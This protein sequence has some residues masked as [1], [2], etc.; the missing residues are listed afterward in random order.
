MKLN[1][2]QLIRQS[3]LANIDHPR[4]RN[5]GYRVGYDGKGRICVGTG[6]ITYNATIG[7]CCM[8]IM[9]DHVEPGAS[10]KNKDTAE[11]NA[12][13]AFACIGNVAIIKSGDAKGETGFVTGKHGGV[14][15]VMIHF[16]H[17]TLLLMDG[18]EKILIQGFG[19]GLK[20]K[21]IPAI[22]VMNID[23]SLLTKIA[24]VTASLLNIAV[25]HIIPSYLMGS[26]LGSSTTMLGD[27]DIMTQDKI[28]VKEL[29]IE[30]MRYGDIVMVEDHNNHYGPHYLKNS[31]S[32]GIVTHSDSYT[33][34]HGPGLTMIL[35]GTKE[36]ICA[37]LDPNAN[38]SNYLK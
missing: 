25:T 36:N 15:H 11:N 37:T 20:I 27:F 32:I 18:D 6:G 38:I 5:D 12:V 4:L 8:N 7:D 29:N 3:L 1:Q 35:S 19:Q 30:T 10:V 9:G 33:S 31:V 21:Q 2:E 22:H 16:N 34:G 28:L 24:N 13:Q 23:P 17:E 14:D 26:G